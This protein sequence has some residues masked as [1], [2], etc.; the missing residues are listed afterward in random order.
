M[1]ST[2]FG[3]KTV[4][5]QDKAR[6]VRGVF[7]AV[8][9]KY[10]VMNDLMSL[11]LHRAWKAFTLAQSGVREGSRVLDIAGGTGDMALE[12]A[13]RAGS[14]GE[15]WLTDINR[16]MLEAGRDRLLDRGASARVLDLIFH[17]P[18]STLDRRNRPKL[19]D[20]PRDQMGRPMRSMAATSR[21]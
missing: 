1:A 4:D 11:G 9:G 16:P 5:E 21:M 10:D 12:F 8:A 17:L 13:R 3:F 6:R 20:A 19:R 2:D 18:H 15:V 7:D 14:T